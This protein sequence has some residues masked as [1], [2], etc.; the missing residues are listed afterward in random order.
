MFIKWG[1]FIFTEIWFLKSEMKSLHFL[2]VTI[3]NLKTIYGINNE[4]YLS[5]NNINKLH[6][7]FKNKKHQLQH[8]KSYIYKGHFKSEY[9]CKDYHKNM[10]RYIENMTDLIGN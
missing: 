1:H 8:A 2:I 6:L 5:I 4:V 10:E 3:I 7:F 9:T